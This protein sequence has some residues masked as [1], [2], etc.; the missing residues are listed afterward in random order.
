VSQMSLFEPAKPDDAVDVWGTLDEEQRTEVAEILARMMAK[1]V[2]APIEN[3][4]K[5]NE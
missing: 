1:I 4:E 5:A 2:A 3:K